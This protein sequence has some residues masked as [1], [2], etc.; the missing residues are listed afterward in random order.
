[1]DSQKGEFNEVFSIGLK[2]NL[3]FR[4]SNLDSDN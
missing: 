1:M 4:F 3:V 2:Q